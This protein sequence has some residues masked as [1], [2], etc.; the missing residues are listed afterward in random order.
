[1]ATRFVRLN[2]S[3]TVYEKKGQGVLDPVLNP[4]DFF[5]RS[6]TNDIAGNTQVLGSLD[7]AYRDEINSQVSAQVDPQVSLAEQQAKSDSELAS[8]SAKRLKDSIAEIY[9]LKRENDP[10]ARQGI[11]SGAADIF[12]TN[13]NVKQVAQADEDLTATL[14]AI[15]GQLGAIKSGAQQQRTGLSNELLNLYRTNNQR[16]EEA[17]N[18]LEMVDRGGSIAFIRPDGTIVREIRKTLTP[19]QGASAS[20]GS[21]ST[22][23]D[24]QRAVQQ[25]MSSGQYTATGE[26]GK[27]SREQLR[28]ELETVFA[29]SGITAEDIA[30]AVYGTN[31][32]SQ[33]V[34]SEIQ[35]SSGKPPTQ[36]QSNAAGFAARIMDTNSTLQRLSPYISSLNASNFAWQSR[37]PNFLKNAQFQE[38]EQAQRN[39]INAVLRRES[40]AAIAD[41]EFENARRQYFPQPGDS[42]E[43]IRQKDRNRQQ[44]LESISTSAGP[45]FVGPVQSGGGAD[46]LGIR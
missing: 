4:E 8:T 32:L 3:G 34:L 19:G 5:R 13:Q 1:M 10:L 36:D 17:R 42:P 21:Y 18:K 43:V 30:K 20:A 11:Y 27:K 23:V 15:A 37:I 29:G 2:N 25:A 35:R 22:G 41:S 28:S 33:Q 6:G 12:S 45:A 16:A 26:A 9:R 39:F 14:K 44:V 24:L 46:P 40:G 7:D 31:N 38:F